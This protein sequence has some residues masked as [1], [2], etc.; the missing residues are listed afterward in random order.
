MQ[1]HSS[2]LIGANNE[3]G[4]SVLVHP[5]WFPAHSETKRPTW[6]SLQGK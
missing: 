1:L 3:R 6:F 2:L 5:A 4:N